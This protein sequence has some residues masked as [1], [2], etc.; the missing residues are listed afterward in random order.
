MAVVIIL[1]RKELRSILTSS[2]PR[3]KTYLL[4]V[5]HYIQDEFDFIPEWALQIVSW[6]LRVPASEVYGAATSYS[7]IRFVSNDN[8]TVRVCSGLSC[9]YMGGKG[10]YDQLCSDVGNE[11]CVEV[12]NCAFTCSMAPLVEISG[13]WFSRS[14]VQSALNQILRRSD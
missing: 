9:W 14:T 8:Q 12:T 10:I 2:F 3:E 6:H 7:D 5:L 11:V 13:Q 1:E 4:P